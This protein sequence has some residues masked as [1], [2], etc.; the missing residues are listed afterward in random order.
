MFTS[1]TLLPGHPEVGGDTC[2]A[3]MYSSFEGLSEGLKDMLRQMKAWHSSRHVFGMHRK[4]RETTQTG[5]IGNAELATQ[6]AVHPVVI[7]HPLSGREALYVNPEFTVRFDGWND[8]ESK[9]LLVF[10]EQHC[11]KPEYTC[12]IRWAPGTITIWDNR[13]TWHKAVND[14]HGQRRFMHRIT[15]EGPELSET[16][17]AA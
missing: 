5:R 12:R 15:V 8:D 3:S 17:A 10:L 9:A 16:R 7:S 4:D 11:T 6:D 14:Y 2:F 1:R 13:A